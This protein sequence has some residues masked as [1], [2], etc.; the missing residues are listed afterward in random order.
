MKNRIAFLAMTAAVISACSGEQAGKEEA[1]VDEFR[2]GQV[3]TYKT[4]PGEEASRLIVCRVETHAKTGTI[5]HIHVEGVAFKNPA[6][7]EG[8]GR[9]IGHMPFAATALRESVKTLESTRESL[10][11]YEEGYNAWKGAF[12][13]GHAGTFT[14]SVAE[15]IDF[16][17]QALSR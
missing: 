8:V 1:A 4:R 13:T 10:P 5:I 3:W 15:G 11:D 6:S 2:P 17:E 16:M 12:D 14:V 7:P 9:T